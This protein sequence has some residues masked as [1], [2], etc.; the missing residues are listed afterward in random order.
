V[1][2]SIPVRQVGTPDDVARVVQLLLDRENGYITG[3]TIFVCGGTS[4]SGSGGE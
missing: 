4:V 2:D 3:Q 1:I